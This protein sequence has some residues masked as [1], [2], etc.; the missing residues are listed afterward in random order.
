MKEKYDGERR[1]SKQASNVALHVV[2]SEAKEPNVSSAIY[3]DLKNEYGK[4]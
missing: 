4:R 2:Q 3:L 1:K